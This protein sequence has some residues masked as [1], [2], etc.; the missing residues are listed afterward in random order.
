MNRRGFLKGILS[1]GV[2]PYVV[3]SAGVLM[4][5]RS[6]ALPEAGHVMVGQEILSIRLAQDGTRWFRRAGSSVWQ[7]D[8]I[9]LDQALDFMREVL[10][11]QGIEVIG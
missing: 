5:V 4:P 2:A 3:T 9:S 10:A 1:A 11:P 8:T 7:P 6:I